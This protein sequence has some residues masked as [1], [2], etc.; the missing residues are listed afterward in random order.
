KRI[1]SICPP[2]SSP[3]PRMMARL[4]LSAGILTA[5]AAVI[6]VRKR[7]LASGSPP[8]RAAIMISLIKRVNTL[9]RLASRAAFLCLMVAHLLCPD[10]EN[11]QFA[12]NFREYQRLASPL[13]HAQG[14]VQT[15]FQQISF[16]S[17]ISSIA[18]LGPSRPRPLCLAP[19]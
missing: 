11:P 19:P 1:S 6:A 5:L 12:F 18:Y 10:I 15:V 8:P 3:V 2:S 4:M 14:S 16:G 13:A 17:V 9:P 7:G